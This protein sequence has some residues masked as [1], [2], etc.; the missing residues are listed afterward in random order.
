MINLPNFD[1]F[2]NESSV[3]L[4]KI[5]ERILNKEYTEVKF[6]H[7]KD[8]Q[9]YALKIAKESFKDNCEIKNDRFEFNWPDQLLNFVVLLMDRHG[10]PE[11]AFFLMRIESGF[12]QPT[13]TKRK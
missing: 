8:W 13:F 10:I 1:E 2:I 5:H 6:F 4:L 11:N 3:K 12:V 9:D 7:R